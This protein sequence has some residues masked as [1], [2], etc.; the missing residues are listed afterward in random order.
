V[1]VT[2]GDSVQGTLAGI[3]IGQRD[4]LSGNGG[5][6]STRSD[7]PDLFG[8]TDARRN[9]SAAGGL[10]WVHR[11]TPRISGTIRY[12][13]SRGVSKALPYFGSRQ[14]ISGEA[15][16]SGNDRDP[17]NWGP[18]ALIFAGGIARLSTGS[19][20]FDR[21]QSH[22]ISYNSAWI[23]GPHTFTYGA[24]FK[25]QQDNLLSQQNARGAFTFTGSATGNDFADFLLGIPAAS[26]LAFGNAD[27]YFRQH[28]SSTFVND[29]LRIVRNMTFSL[30]VRWEYESPVIEKDGRLV[31]LDFSPGFVSAKP[32]VA[33]TRENSLLIRD[34]SG[35]QPRIGLAWRPR[36][37][38]SV[39]VRAGYGIY[40]DT[41]VYR[42]I[43][44]QMS[45]QSPLSKSL[46]VQNTPDHPLTLE[47]GFR[48]SPA[49]T[50][51]TFAVD[52][53]FRPGNAQNWTLA[54][55]RDLPFAMQ[56]VVTYLGI[57]GTHVPQR[58]LP[59]TFPAG[60][61]NPCTTCPVGFVY[62][63][64][65]GNTNRH[66]GSIELRRR[67]QNGFEIMGR[68]TYAKAIDDAGLGGA[69][70]VAQNWLNVRAE[71]GLSSFDQRHQLTLQGQYTT[72]MFA[73]IGSF[74]GGWY[75]ALLRGWTL[76]SQLTFGSGLPLTPTLFAPV[77]G[78]GITGTLRPNVTGAPLLVPGTN[79]LNSAAFTAPQPGEWGNAARNSI[80][81]P[82]QFQMDASLGRAFRLNER[83]SMDLRVESTNVLNHVAFTS[84]NTIVNNSQFG[85]PIRANAMRTL[86]PSLRVRF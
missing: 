15:G 74:E 45:Q 85:L 47:D 34:R 78:T 8:F 24:D 28:L 9:V 6:Q 38:S 67:Q 86:R 52:P 42:A 57:K 50:P 14:D 62:L 18:P 13:F 71:R 3:R 32:V 17:R 64:S 49:A 27:K 70:H 35:F 26:A 69:N 58:I 46:S 40:R 2:H 81:G 54:I 68:Y 72:G 30:G 23:R 44:D 51:T 53:R 84:L 19:Y 5:F 39:V 79:V 77:N 12:T 43:A 22:S 41:G 31:N 21:R 16:I 83:V 63:T 48:G 33:G 76:S 4:Q 37:A 60:T 61:A 1:G 10:N 56:V 25:S 7:N 82:G 11:F 75:G 66:A 29:D 59:N 55:Q 80:R 20:A 65:S 73:G 36:V